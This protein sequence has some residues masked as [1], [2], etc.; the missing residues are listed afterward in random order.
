MLECFSVS[1]WNKKT[2]HN[3]STRPTA[4]NHVLTKRDLGC[5]QIILQGELCSDQLSSK[6]NVVY[7]FALTHN[8]TSYV[9]IGETDGHSAVVL[10]CVPTLGTAPR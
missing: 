1:Y 4:C 6:T 9:C 7:I 3:D 10:G 2:L 5:V 8:I